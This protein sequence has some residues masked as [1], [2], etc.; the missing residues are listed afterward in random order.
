MPPVWSN[1]HPFTG[2][3]SAS[4]ADGAGVGVEVGDPDGW[5]VCPERPSRQP[6]AHGRISPQPRASTVR[7]ERSI[8]HEEAPIGDEYLVV[9]R[10]GATDPGDD[11]GVWSPLVTCPPPPGL[12][13]SSIFSHRSLTD[14]DQVRLPTIRPWSVAD[15]Q[16]LSLARISRLRR[17]SGGRRLPEEDQHHRDE[18]DQ[19]IDDDGG[20]RIDQPDRRRLP[21]EFS[22]REV[23]R[24][25]DVGEPPVC[26]YNPRHD[27]P[28]EQ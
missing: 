12:R 9:T 26:H 7:R 10:E 4:L 2:S 11:G 6:L 1:R 3:G 23:G 21:T 19:R 16:A 13:S 18:Q 25:R 5:G 14:A 8:Q 27:A 28:D 24:F 15:R 17:A 22:H 20:R